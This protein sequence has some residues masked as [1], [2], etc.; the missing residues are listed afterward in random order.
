MKKITTLLVSIFFFANAYSQNYKL[1]LA[2]PT[3][4]GTFLYPI[5]MKTPQ[6]GTNRMFVVEKH[7]K[8]YVI[9]NDILPTTKKVFLDLSAIVSQSSSSGETGL[10][11]L[12]FHPKIGRAHV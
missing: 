4:S 12:A 5:E 7:G 2:Y 9:H 6:D 1:Q 3:L 8:I 10:L 11:G